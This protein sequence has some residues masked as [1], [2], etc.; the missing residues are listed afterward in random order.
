LSENDENY[1]TYC[2]KYHAN[3]ESVVQ[4]AGF[5]RFPKKIRQDPS[6]ILCGAWFLFGK[7]STPSS[8]IPTMIQ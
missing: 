5:L 3:W 2:K 4:T 7:A 8:A 6:N 1:P